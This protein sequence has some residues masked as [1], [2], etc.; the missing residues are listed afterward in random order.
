MMRSTG[1]I[2]PLTRPFRPNMW[3]QRLHSEPDL[4]ALDLEGLD[5]ERKPILLNHRRGLIFFQQVALH[6]F[7]DGRPKGDGHC[8]AAILFGFIDAHD[9][10]PLIL[11]LLYRFE[12]DMVS[13][14]LRPG[15]NSG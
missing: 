3:P 13:I 1:A 8:V 12:D 10:G 2:L 15:V 11:S 4:E 9:P 5:G 14:Q 6:C 7:A